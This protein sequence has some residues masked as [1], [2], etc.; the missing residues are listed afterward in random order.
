MPCCF[1]VKE[2][3]KKH[4]TMIQQAKIQMKKIEELDSIDQRNIEQFTQDYAKHTEIEKTKVTKKH[5]DEY[6]KQGS[7][8][9]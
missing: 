5:K 6:I 1:N 3:N 9:P 2:N 7:S 8:F 4:E